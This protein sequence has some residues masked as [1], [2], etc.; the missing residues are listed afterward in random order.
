[1]QRPAN[2]RID[3]ICRGFTHRLP[4]IITTRPAHDLFMTASCLCSPPAALGCGA[5]WP[6][7]ANRPACLQAVQAGSSRASRR[8]AVGIS[9][10]TETKGRVS[11]SRFG[12]QPSECGRRCSHASPVWVTRCC[13]HDPCLSDPSRC[14][15]P[16]LPPHSPNHQLISPPLLSSPSSRPHSLSHACLHRCFLS[17][18]PVVF[19]RRPSTPLHVELSPAT[20]HCFGRAAPPRVSSL[21]AVL[22][23][24][25]V[26]RQRTNLHSSRHHHKSPFLS[27]SPPL[28]YYNHRRRRVLTLSL[29]PLLPRKIPLSTQHLALY[30]A[31]RTKNPPRER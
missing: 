15:P 5:G 8:L 12:I 10:G 17:P 26:I 19:V 24:S 16:C 31:T 20:C 4:I 13:H 22:R 7:L 30:V 3:L 28:L 6:A 21:F 23:S 29:Q 9:S 11:P 2:G 18:P 27:L 1:M 14:H 25:A